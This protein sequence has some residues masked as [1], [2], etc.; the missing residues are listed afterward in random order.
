MRPFRRFEVIFSSAFVLYPCNNQ[1][2]TTV[3]SLFINFRE[4]FTGLRNKCLRARRRCKTAACISP[5]VVL[6]NS[7]ELILALSQFCSGPPVNLLLSSPPLPRL[8]RHPRS[9]SAQ[10]VSPA[11]LSTWPADLNSGLLLVCCGPCHLS[12]PSDH[13]TS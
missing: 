9:R 13:N 11:R 3:Y 8:Y 7:P 5:C 10:R 12:S 1:P 2:T 6:R 4:A